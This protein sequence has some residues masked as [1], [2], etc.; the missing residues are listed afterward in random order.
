MTT[1]K[2]KMKPAVP[3]AATVW[4]P[5][6]SLPPERR[7]MEQMPAS[8]YLGQMLQFIL[9]PDDH[10]HQ[11]PT[12]LIGDE[13]PIYYGAP[14]PGGGPPPHL[15][16]DYLVALDVDARAIWNR[17]GYDP[18]QNGK[19]PDVVVEVASHSTYRNDNV[20]KREI[21][22]QIGVPEYWR[23]DPTGGDYYGQ[24]I[25]GEALAGG[26][27]ERL[28]LTRYADGSEGATSAILKVNFRWRGARFYVHDP[29]SGEEYE[30]AM[31]AAARQRVEMAH[32]QTEMERQQ[33]EIARL[34]A[35]NRRLR[36]KG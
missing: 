16:P 6:P 35:E 10:Y 29:V 22:R 9:T 13:I 36:G 15:V 7:D 25:I 23:F 19:P 11:H 5:Y 32:Q 21:Y 2:P 12:I 20:G 17:I 1:A 26:E 28:P 14:R 33:A 24:A 31:A 30:H 4:E 8:R 18:I 27:Y 34:Q 3:G